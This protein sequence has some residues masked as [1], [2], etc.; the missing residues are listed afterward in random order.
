MFLGFIS[1]APRSRRNEVG[2]PLVWWPMCMLFSARWK[3]RQFL[4]FA[5]NNFLDALRNATV[6]ELSSVAIA[7]RDLYEEHEGTA[8]IQDVSDELLPIVATRGAEMLAD[9]TCVQYLCENKQR[10]LHAL[11]HEM[12]SM[13]ATESQRVSNMPLFLPSVFMEHYGARQALGTGRG[14]GLQQR[15]R[16]DFNSDPSTD[17]IVRV[18][19]CGSVGRDFHTH[20]STLLA[21]SSF[22]RSKNV[23]VSG[24]LPFVMGRPFLVYHFSV[25]AVQA[26]LEHIHG[27]SFSTNT[28]GANGLDFLKECIQ[29]GHEWAVTSFRQDAAWKYLQAALALPRKDIWQLAIDVIALAVDDN[30]CCSWVTSAIL[31]AATERIAAFLGDPISI[32]IFSQ[33]DGRILMSLCLQLAADKEY[34]RGYGLCPPDDPPLQRVVEILHHREHA[35]E[36]RAESSSTSH[37]HKATG[38]SSEINN[39][40]YTGWRRG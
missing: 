2:H 3:N 38:S 35:S 13:S 25:E 18:M 12:S 5:L 23:R 4:D 6:T 28:T 7:L 24:H 39:A 31:E 30:E 29:L 16:M 19:D 27:I 33:Y 11:A 21:A 32:N 17:C 22:F 8:T 34:I 40:A 20:R 15:P 10:S 26:C 1:G 9:P 37:L 36:G 14:Y